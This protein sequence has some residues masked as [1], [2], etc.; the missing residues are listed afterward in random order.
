MKTYTVVADEPAL[1]CEEPET[2]IEKMRGL[3]GRDGLPEGRV[4]LIR[5]CRLIHTFGMRFPLD[6]IFVNAYGK[7]VKTARK[8]RPG[9]V[10][11]GGFRARHTIEAQAGWVPDGI[12]PGVYLMDHLFKSDPDSGTTAIRQWKILWRKKNGE[13]HVK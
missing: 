6:V 8:L 2:H 12:V 4:M 5:D 10:A 7:V 11:F 9:R 3:L 1:V 13:L